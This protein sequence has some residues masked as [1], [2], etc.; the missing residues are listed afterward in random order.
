MS[1]LLIIGIG[2]VFVLVVAWALRGQGD[3]QPPPYDPETELQVSLE[4]RAIHTRLDVARLK[5]E[6]RQT[7]DRA[8]RELA[9][10]LRDLND[11]S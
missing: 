1:H 10:E 2:M 3:K 4:L 5:S 8:R 7:F 6:Q 9:D 11:A